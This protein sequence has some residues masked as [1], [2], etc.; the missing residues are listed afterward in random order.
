M[1][2]DGF[3][4]KANGKIL[5]VA[6]QPDGKILI[7]GEFTTL[8]PNNGPTVTRNRIARLNANGSVDIAFN[9][10]ANQTVIGL[11][12]QPDGKVLAGGFFSNIGGQSRNLVARLDAMTGQADSFD[13]SP[14]CSP[15]DDPYVQAIVV[16]ADGKIL[17]GGKFERIGPIQGQQTRH[18]IARLDPASGVADAFDPNA[19]F[20]V[21]GI[22]VQGDKVVV[23]GEFTMI[24]GQPR[25]H[26]ARLNSATGVADPLNP[27]AN[28]AVNS[29]ALQAD[30]K[31]V[32]G[33]TFT[34]IG[35]AS[36]NRLA[37]ID[38]ATGAVD[39]FDPNASDDVYAV[40]IQPDGS[41]LAGG[42]FTLIGGQ[43]RNRIAR[44]NSITG[45]ADAFN[46]NSSGDVSSLAVVASDNPL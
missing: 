22:A 6:V 23:G 24:G 30:G 28:G 40:V 27:N 2:F 36:R 5:A 14:S 3:D 7:G 17:M 44:F 31:I 37:R 34:G 45:M 19:D 32:A 20:P 1:P 43:T 8:A 26:L 33:G 15:C 4:P 42:S 35:G 11:A 38:P 41:I 16:Q 21:H 12:I 13:P 9:P 25:N 46:P 10:N 18:H 39:S 29:L